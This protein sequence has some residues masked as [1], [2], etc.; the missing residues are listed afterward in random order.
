MTTLHIEHPI[1]D[2][3]IWST[4]FHQFADARQAAGVRAHRVQR[5]V[6]D[7]HYVVVDLEFDDVDAAVAF[8]HFLTTVVWAIPGNAPALVGTPKATVLEPASM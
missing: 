3:E 8:R 5:P 1:T 2:F 7:P 6:D 4:S